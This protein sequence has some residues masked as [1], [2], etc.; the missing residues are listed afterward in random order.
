MVTFDGTAR[1]VCLTRR[2]RTNTPLQ[3]LTV[4]NDSTY[5]DLSVK[6][7]KKL[8]TDSKIQGKDKIAIGYEMATGKP[9]NPEKNKILTEL[10]R[11][12]LF[13]LS[14]KDDRVKA[15]IADS[16]LAKQ[17]R[18]IAALSVVTSAILNLDEVITTN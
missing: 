8:Y 6:L 14:D 13:Q 2:I 10:Y 9:I 3:A 16:I 11:K 4:L 12:T 15:M 7:A 17:S 18:E 1:E 5:W